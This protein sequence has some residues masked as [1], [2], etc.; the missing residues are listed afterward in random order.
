MQRHLP[1]LIT[2]LN[3]LFGCLAIVF[4]LNGAYRTVLYLFLG[5]V[6]MDYADGM[7]A[8]LLN[9]SSPVG[10]ELDSLADMV[11]FGVVPGMIY[12]TLLGGSPGEL[13]GGL[14]VAGFIV[15]LFA[16]VRLAKF[17][18]D[19]RQTSDFIGLPTPSM[20][21]FAVGLLAVV[22]QDLFGWREFV[23]HPAFLLVCVVFFAWIMVAEFPMFSGKFKGFGW[24]GNEIRY[25]FAAIALAWVIALGS[26]GFS[27]AILTY[28]LLAAGHFFLKKST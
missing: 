12:F 17:N 8:R 28:L 4:L 20:T 16:A 2:L 24:R 11:S 3:S 5:S 10:K 18:L 6:A 19:E 25:I 22:E 23:L 1:N 26:A 14:P 21:T 7:V 13:Q 27:F 9:V 15:T